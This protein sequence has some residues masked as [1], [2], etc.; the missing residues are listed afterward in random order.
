LT[1]R[2]A[3]VAA[4]GKPLAIDVVFELGLESGRYLLLRS[5]RGWLV[6]LVPPALGE[7]LELPGKLVPIGR[8]PGGY[9]KLPQ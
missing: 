1:I 4:S 9:P 7:S 5:D 2:I 3:E 6:E 8:P